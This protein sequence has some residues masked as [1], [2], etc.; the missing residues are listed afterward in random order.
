MKSKFLKFNPAVDKKILVLL[1]GAIWCGIGLM[2][3]RFSLVWL[4]MFEIKTQFIFGAAG[5]IAAFPIYY[6]G[7]LKLADKNLVRLL[8]LKEKRCIFSFMTWK[9]YLIVPVM[10]AVGVLLRHSPLP[11]QY[12]SIIYTGIGIGL[13]LSGLRYFRFFFSLV[14]YKKDKG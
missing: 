8:P 5:L 10:V 13:F 2:L 7:F 12:L 3:L 6:F 9:S 11:K 1:A 4:S 14:F